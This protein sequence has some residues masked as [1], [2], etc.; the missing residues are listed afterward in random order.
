MGDTKTSVLFDMTMEKAA[1]KAVR[2]Y[3]GGIIFSRLTQHMAYANDV[4]MVARLL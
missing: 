2:I 1:D 3:S 4:G